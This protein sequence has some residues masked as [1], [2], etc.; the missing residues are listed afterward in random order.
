MPI[1]GH[2]RHDL[3]PQTLQY[4]RVRKHV[5]TNRR[6][7]RCSCFR[8]SPNEARRFLGIILHISVRLGKMLRIPELV[9]DILHTDVRLLHREDIL[10]LPNE[11]LTE[12]SPRLE[13]L[14]DQSEHT[15]RQFSQKTEQPGHLS[16]PLM[17][18]QVVVELAD[19]D[20]F[21]FAAP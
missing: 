14:V 17:L 12:L 5:I 2:Y 4:R 10:D 8:A 21:F 6:K 19:E 7:R 3:V 16:A 20:G 13:R 18:V 15:G 11:L 9:E 1:F